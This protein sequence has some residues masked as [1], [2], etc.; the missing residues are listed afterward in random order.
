[1]IFSGVSFFALLRIVFLLENALSFLAVTGN[2][3]PRSFAF[4]KSRPPESLVALVLQDFL[5]Y[6]Q[7]RSTL[8]F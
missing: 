6:T 1:M 3:S 7:K 4:V 2:G 5:L 8:S